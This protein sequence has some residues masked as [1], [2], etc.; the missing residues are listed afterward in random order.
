MPKKKKANKAGKVNITSMNTMEKCCSPKKHT[1]IGVVA[2][3]AGILYL[4]TD[5][6][7]LSFA[8]N[9]WTVV[10]LLAGIAL[11]LHKK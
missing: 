6:K 10:F 9:P 8:I 5:I 11:V 2:L 1:I 3:V 7:V 4:L